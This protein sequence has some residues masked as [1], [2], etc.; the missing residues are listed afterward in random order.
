MRE[1]KAERD[2]EK[3]GQN[4]GEKELGRQRVR[5]GVKERQR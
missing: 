1:R 2:E 4:D 5:V 3:D